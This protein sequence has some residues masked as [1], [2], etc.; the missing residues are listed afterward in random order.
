MAWTLCAVLAA[1]AAGL[2]LRVLV[3]PGPGG[4]QEVPGAAA[5]LYPP[6]PDAQ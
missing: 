5:P 1:L 2:A 4:V 6:P 3:P